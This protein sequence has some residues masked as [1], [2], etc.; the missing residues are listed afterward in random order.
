M[1][2][3]GLWVIGNTWK[4]RTRRIS[5]GGVRP[6]DKGL[7][8]GQGL[9]GGAPGSTVGSTIE[10]V[11]FEVVQVPGEQ[12]HS[13][14]ASL[15]RHSAPG[16]WWV[17]IM[18]LP[19]FSRCVPEALMYLTEE[20]FTTGSFKVAPWSSAVGHHMTCE[21]GSAIAKDPWLFSHKHLTPP[22]ASRMKRRQPT[23]QQWQKRAGDT[24]LPEQKVE[25]QGKLL[26]GQGPQAMGTGPGNSKKFWEGLRKA[27]QPV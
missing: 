19:R 23:W 3:A 4:I 6:A 25:K 24:P 15:F 9:W 27:S 21:E 26:S 10:W 22:E 8:R 17:S 18:S 16:P 11:T 5:F 13:N 7:W 1:V 20:L 14:N 2:R 12:N